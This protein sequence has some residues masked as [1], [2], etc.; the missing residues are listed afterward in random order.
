MTET[1]NL[2]GLLTSEATPE[3]VRPYA[4][5]ARKRAE[6]HRSEAERLD[7]FADKL[8]RWCAKHEDRS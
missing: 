1:D 3:K 6:Y 8:Y 2:G 7:A 5:Q 4:F